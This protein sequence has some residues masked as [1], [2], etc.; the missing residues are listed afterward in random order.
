MFNEE[1][2][3]GATIEDLLKEVGLT[4]EEVFEEK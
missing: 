3:Y 1:M 2:M 4:E